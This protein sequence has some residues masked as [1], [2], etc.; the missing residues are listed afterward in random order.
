MGA[1]GAADWKI[2]AA[3]QYRDIFPSA[4]LRLAGQQ[5]P[6]V[7]VFLVPALG[8]TSRI[9]VQRIQTAECLDRDDVPYIFRHYM[10]C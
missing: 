8:A 7:A 10:S 5:A 2:F 3:A 1:D 4:G 6:G 9:E